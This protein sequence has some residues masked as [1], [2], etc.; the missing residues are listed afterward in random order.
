MRI[1]T[2]PTP[3]VSKYWEWA[4]LIGMTGKA[5]AI[6]PKGLTECRHETPET[7]MLM[8]NVAQAGFTVCKRCIAKN[9]EFGDRD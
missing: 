3:D 8:R 5:H 2:F 4:G 7:Y 6:T 1:Q 9:A